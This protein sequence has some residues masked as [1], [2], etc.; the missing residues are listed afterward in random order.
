[1]VSEHLKLW[2]QLVPTVSADV[3]VV[4][5]VDGVVE[6]REAS[7]WRRHFRQSR[8]EACFTQAED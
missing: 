5:D 2:H 3:S 1:M 7:A 4:D 6:R 8:L